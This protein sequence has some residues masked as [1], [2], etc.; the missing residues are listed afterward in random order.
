[1]KLDQV[2]SAA[3]QNMLKST[4][5]NT[6]KNTQAATQANDEVSLSNSAKLGNR[7]LQ[8]SLSQSLTINGKNYSV[9]TPDQ[10]DDESTE[11]LFDFQ[12]VADNVLS[13]V[14]N[15][16]NARK[17]AGDDN[18]ALEKML[19]QARKGIDQ[20][21]TDARKELDKSGTLTDPLS[22]GIDKS[23][24]LIQKGLKDFEKDLFGQS[25]DGSTTDNA[26]SDATT[27]DAAQ[28]TDGTKDTKTPKEI[29]NSILAALSGQQS[30]SLELTTKEGDKITIQF[31]DQQQW[32]QQQNSGLAKKALQTYG[33]LGGNAKKSDTKNSNS[34][35][36]TFYSHTT[37]FSFKV[38]GD[39]N[40]SELKS[41]SDMVNKVGNLSD[42]FFGGNIND[43]LQQAQKLDLSDSE[44]TSLSLDLYQKQA[45]GLQ[46]N[47]SSD[48]LANASSDS[49]ATTDSASSSDTTNNQSGLP[50][51][52]QAAAALPDVF[53]QLGDYLT[54]LQSMFN[55]MI[56]SFNPDSQGNLQSWVAKQQHP[57]KSDEQIGQ[58]VSFN[59]RMQQAMASLADNQQTNPTDTTAA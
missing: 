59:Q 51:N 6:G 23:Y 55:Q 37:Q 13:F 28:T 46:S 10:A 18:E 48:A 19:G 14:T 30:A 35:S 57:E 53:S 4:Q 45:F 11:S 5:R 49:S 34:D 20:G 12:K 39:L 33:E 36:S 56:A 17:Q 21:F 41:I 47:S 38:E 43:A 24:D 40:S 50:D 25:T 1:M 58:F 27:T 9:K 54:Q 8:F 22:K 15:T 7:V 3:L 29:G 16:I 44:L 31:D 42:S 52:Q 32:R 26:T 2:N